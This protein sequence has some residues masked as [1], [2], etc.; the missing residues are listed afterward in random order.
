MYKKLIVAM[1]LMV[2]VGLFAA[3]DA[4]AQ[5]LPAPQAYSAVPDVVVV[6]SQETANAGTF[7]SKRVL[8]PAGM[9]A[10]GG[11]IDMSNVFNMQVTSSAPVFQGQRLIQRPVGTNPAPDGWQASA[12]NNAGYAQTFKVAVVCARMAGVSTVVG[13]ED[14][15][16]GSFDVKRVT[17]PAGKVA[18]GGGIDM[19]NVIS[20]Q[21]SSSAPIISGDRLIQR[22]DG[23]NPAPEAWQASALNTA[24]ASQNFK[25]AVICGELTGVSTI[26]GSDDAPA[27]SFDTERA[28]CPSGKV[29]LSGGVD[30]ENVI[31]MQVSSTAPVFPP[32]DRLITRPAGINPAPYAWQVSALN[33]AG[34]PQEF[35][36]GAV[37]A[38]PAYRIF[39]P[40]L[41]E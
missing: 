21:V 41:V 28:V 24:G 36:V 39:T 20:M 11:G 5:Q 40:L 14:A 27:G 19:D 16:A 29:A 9:V 30:M 17:C 25:V 15:P 18:L 26:I 8:C 13:M 7:G 12:L 34:S 38:T 35:K 1:A 32:S 31:S 22:L 3:T 6:V 10:I 37:C 2:S 23:T 4:P 33:D